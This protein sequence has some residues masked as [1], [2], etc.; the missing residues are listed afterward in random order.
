MATEIIHEEHVIEER[1]H[2]QAFFV[3][4]RVFDFAFGLLYAL[5]LVRFALVF[6]GARP[7]AGF[8]Q[9]IHE[10]TEPF[11]RPFEG[12]FATSSFAGWRIEWPILVAILAYALL[13]WVIR[14]VLSLV[15]RARV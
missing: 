9:L 5:L 4:A 13:H 2:N 14:G 15:G 3:V 8:Y 12:L 7:G 1:P 6:F 10:S 11:Y